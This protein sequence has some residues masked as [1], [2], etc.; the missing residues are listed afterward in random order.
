MHVE[1]FFARNLGGLIHARSLLADVRPKGGAR[2]VSSARRDL[3]G[4]RGAIPVPTFSLC[5]VGT[6]VDDLIGLPTPDGAAPIPKH[7]LT[8]PK[9]SMVDEISFLIIMQ[10]LA[11]L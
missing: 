10:L 8:A 4:G 2:C 5:C 11:L 3:C 9:S 7:N 6:I 1:K